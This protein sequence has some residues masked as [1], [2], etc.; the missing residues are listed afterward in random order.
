MFLKC[1]PQSIVGTHASCNSHMLDARLFHSHAKLFHQN[2]NYRVLQ[3]CSKVFLVMLHKVRIIFH[4]ITQVVEERGFQAAET[5]VHTRN[6]RFRKLVGMRIALTGQPIDYGATRITQSHHLR[7]F[8]DSFTC[9]II[10]GLSEHFHVVVG[11]HLD[12]L[13]VTTTYQQT[14]ERQRR[15]IAYRLAIGSH[16]L[17]EMRHHMTLQVIDIYHW[18]T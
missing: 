14:E 12:N 16:L 3:A 1:I 2:V 5:I 17:D 15:N 18:N 10:D 6:M 11:I 9:C 4:P 13:R 8:V 7:A